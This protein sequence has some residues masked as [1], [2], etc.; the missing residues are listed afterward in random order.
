MNL[1]RMIGNSIG[2]T[3]A[4]D[5]GERLSAWHDAMVAHE[6]R[7]ARNGQ[8]CHDECPHADAGG[9]WDEAVRTLGP[10]SEELLFL[11]SH[12]SR[13]PRSSRRADSPSR[14]MEAGA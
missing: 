11:R 6:R 7:G 10:R 14:S 13:R 1:Y 3:E 4:V 5:L 9:L 2:T 12:G 8:G